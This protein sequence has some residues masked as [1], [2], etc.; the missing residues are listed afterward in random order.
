LLIFRNGFWDLPKG[1]IEK[2][3]TIENAVLREVKEKCGLSGQIYII[4]FFQQTHHVYSL[5]SDSLLNTTD[6]FIMKTTFKE[7]LNPQVEEGISEC[8]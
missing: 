5:G 6:W 3:E 1:H 4:D 8:R 2:N 7:N